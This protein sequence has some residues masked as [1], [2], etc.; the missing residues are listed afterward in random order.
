MATGPISV[1]LYMDFFCDDDNTL[2]ISPLKYIENLVKTY[3]QMFG[4]K[5]RQPRVRYFRVAGL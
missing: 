1:H 2:C 4:E 3:E 5:R